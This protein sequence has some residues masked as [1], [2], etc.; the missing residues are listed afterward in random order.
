MSKS[1]LLR[2]N[3]LMYEKN[4]Q[5]PKS[6]RLCGAS[7]ESQT[8][9]ADTVFGGKIEHNFWQ[10]RNCDAVYLYPIPS[11]EEEAYFYKKEFEEFMAK[12]S[13]V[14]RDWANIKAHIYIKQN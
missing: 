1:K 12:R 9:R 4:S 14:E 2:E 10:C 5:I 11:I 3:R 6:Y 8:V 13:G 7:H